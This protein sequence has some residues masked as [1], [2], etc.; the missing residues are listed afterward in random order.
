MT[1]D[2]FNALALNPPRYE[3]VT[4]CRLDVYCYA[5][6]WEDMSDGAELHLGFRGYYST[7]T[8]ADSSMLQVYESLREEVFRIYCAIIT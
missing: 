3:G 5:D 6:E 7:C 4:I 8:E 1:F 2:E